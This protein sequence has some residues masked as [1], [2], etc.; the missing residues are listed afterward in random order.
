MLSGDD[1]S[2]LAQAPNEKNTAGLSLTSGMSAATALAMR[3]PY[4]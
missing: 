2:A 4:E 1:L 3:L